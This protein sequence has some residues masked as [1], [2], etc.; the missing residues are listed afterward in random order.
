MYRE[1]EK[2]SKKASSCL[3]QRRK[4]WH[5]EVSTTQF[6][7]YQSHF[8]RATG[9]RFRSRPIASLLIKRGSNVNELLS[10][11]AITPHIAAFRVTLMFRTIT[12][13]RGLS[14]IVSEGSTVLQA[15]SRHGDA[16]NVDGFLKPPAKRWNGRI[17][18]RRPS[19]MKQLLGGKERLSELDCQKSSHR[20][21]I[22]DAGFEKG[23]G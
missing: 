21:L 17:V 1:W 11:V 12:G 2:H 19:Y 14:N 3:G 23:N 13:E 22:R 8:R 9:A 15:A 10:A 4:L 18:F 20:R 16:V 7:Y 5:H 6:R